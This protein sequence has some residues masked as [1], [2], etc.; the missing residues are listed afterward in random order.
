MIKKQLRIREIEALIK[1]SKMLAVMIS[2]DKAEHLYFKITR[3]LYIKIQSGCTVLRA[4]AIYFFP[5][6]VNYLSYTKIIAIVI[7]GVQ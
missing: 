5:N 7:M 4:L 6:S 3:C 2:K 1:L